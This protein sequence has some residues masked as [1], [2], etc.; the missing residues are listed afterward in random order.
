MTG[1]QEPCT[2]QRFY[3]WGMLLSC[4]GLLFTPFACTPTRDTKIA[5]DAVVRFHA[6]LGARNYREIYAA[7]DPEFRK[8]V[9]ENDAIAY[10]E[11][12]NRKLGVIRKTE[13]RGSNVNVSPDRTIITLTY[14]TEFAEGLAIEDF[15]WRIE[16][17]KALLFHYNFNRI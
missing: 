1:S 14:H 17:D 12:I 10:F 16:G 7:A 3:S 6:M 11:A 9:S 8:E 5:T 13:L 4:L 15:T 2:S